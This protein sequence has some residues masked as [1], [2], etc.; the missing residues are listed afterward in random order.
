MLEL[1]RIREQKDEV[2]AG[3]SKRCK[4][5]DLDAVIAEDE[6]RRALLTETESLKAK[7]NKVSKEIPM[8]KKQG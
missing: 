7:R 1:K 5:Y 4:T 3:L 6:K 8:M 2:A